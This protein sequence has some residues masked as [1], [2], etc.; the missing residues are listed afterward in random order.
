MRGNAKGGPGASEF[1]TAVAG[2]KAP[3]QVQVI[4]NGK[5]VT[6]VSL[7]VKPKDTPITA[8][9][10]ENDGDLETKATAP[11]VETGANPI[12]EERVTGKSL[13]KGQHDE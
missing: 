1:G 12:E 13:S 6:P 9:T 11:S 2:T 10:V 7:L 3:A 4:H 5:I 8:P